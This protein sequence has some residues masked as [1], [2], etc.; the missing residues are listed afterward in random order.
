MFKIKRQNITGPEL[1]L[2]LGMTM[3]VVCIIGETFNFMAI[4][5]NKGRMPVLWD[6]HY[7]SDRHFTYQNISEVKSWYLTDIFTIGDYIFSIGDF[8][9]YFGFFS[10]MITIFLFIKSKFVVTTKRRKRR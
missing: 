8:I 4:S 3:L 5:E 7:E 10:Y 2:L 6:A 1:L 9:I